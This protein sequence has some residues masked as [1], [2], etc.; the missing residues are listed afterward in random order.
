[1]LTGRSWFDDA[2]DPSLFLATK[3]PRERGGR[4]SMTP[5]KR[6]KTKKRAIACTTTQTGKRRGEGE[7]NSD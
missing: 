6:K 4:T 5:P 3:H 7:S 2:R 1:M